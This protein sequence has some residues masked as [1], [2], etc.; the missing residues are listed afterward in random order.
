MIKERSR[1]AK[2]IEDRLIDELIGISRG[3][4]ADDRVDES[5]A[6]FIGQWIETHREIADKWPVNVLYARIKELL[7]D[8]RL[9]S[10]EQLELLNTLKDITGGG[11]SLVEPTKSTTLPLTQPEP[12]VKFEGAVF[13]LTGKFVFG[14]TGECEEVI[15][16]LGGS[17]VPVPTAETDYLIIGEMGSP[18]WIHSAFG[19]SIE[20]AMELRERGHEIAIVSEEHWVD[21]LAR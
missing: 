12:E 11:I 6:I 4:I 3:V 21:E 14:S 2:R 9:D 7:K 18:D 8:G 20:H 10:A 5:E 17:I 16:A 15:E 1:N 19:R 13:A